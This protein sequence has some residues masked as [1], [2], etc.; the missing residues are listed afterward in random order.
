MFKV[1][2]AKRAFGLCFL[3]LAS[4]VFA[5]EVNVYSHRHYDSDK[6]LFKE[7]EKESGIKVNVVTAK[8]EELLVRLKM[9]DKNSP[10]D[11]FITADVG[12]LEQAKEQGLLQPIKSEILETNIPQH[13]RDSE[14][15]WFGLTKRARVVVY[16]KD[17]INPE[18]LSTYEALADDKFRGKL[19]MRSSSNIYNQSL[20]AS[21]I[22]N[23][24][25]DEAL[26][27]AKGIV[28]NFAREPK[29]NDRDQIRAVASGDGVVT[30]V[31]TYY[32]GNM[33]T[34]KDEKDRAIVERVGIFFPNQA[35]R[36]THINVSGGGVTKYAKNTDEAQ[37]LLEF[38]SSK[39]AQTLFAEANFEY[40]VNPEVAPSKLVASWGEFKEDKLEL[41]NIGKYNKEA[42]AIFSEASWK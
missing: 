12:N 39:K 1:S 19:V 42:V 29:G 13:L 27:W 36:G 41:S 18:E 3:T 23:D 34:S 16:N 8:A 22:A 6:E 25:K 24:G 14:S 35:D 28:A 10:A 20:L 38:L 40:P 37:K 15:M 9:E 2:K 17:K 5:A 32:L 33:A 11:I 30:L 31:N 4:A 21:I 26:K 7:F